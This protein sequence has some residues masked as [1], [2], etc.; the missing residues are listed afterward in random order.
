MI[1]GKDTDL[2]AGG[3]NDLLAQDGGMFQEGI[4]EFV[5]HD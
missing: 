1:F 2:G 3:V 4:T 5:S